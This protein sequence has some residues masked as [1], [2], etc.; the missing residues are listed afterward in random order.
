MLENSPGGGS[1]VYSYLFLWLFALGLRPINRAAA[2]PL[3]TPAI[4]ESAGHN[5]ESPLDVPKVKDVS[6]K[7]ERSNT[8]MDIYY[9]HCN[10]MEAAHPSNR[11]VTLVTNVSHKNTLPCTT[12]LTAARC[13]K[14]GGPPVWEVRGRREWQRERSLFCSVMNFSRSTSNPIIDS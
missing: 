11:A 2:S 4:V 13:L 5:C 8:S 6:G 7:W 14:A 1:I 12:T 10:Q 9:M 3:H